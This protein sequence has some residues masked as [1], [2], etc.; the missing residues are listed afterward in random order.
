MRRA[1]PRG[2]ASA[3]AGT[4]GAAGDLAAGFV[5]DI[6]SVGAVG[7][8]TTAEL[9]FSIGQSAV[10]P[11]PGTLALLGLGLAGLLV[12]SFLNVVIHRWPLMLEREWRAESAELLGVPIEPSEPI[13]L[14]RPASR[15]PACGHEIRWHENIPVLGYL[16]RNNERK[17]NK[18]ELLVFITPRIIND[19]LGLR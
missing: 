4:I 8:T 7:T 18:T 13:S 5:W 12:G 3:L 15:C 2:G 16:F 11:T 6:G 14:S 1:A 10:V 17:D 19:Q 9:A